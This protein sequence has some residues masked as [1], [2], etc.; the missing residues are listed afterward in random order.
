[1]RWTI[2]T[3]KQILSSVICGLSVV[4]WASSLSAQLP[5]IQLR[6][7]FP[8][9]ATQGSEIDLQITDG[10]ELDELSGLSFS[11]P[12]L[13][14]VNPPDPL[15]NPRTFRV[16]VSADVP[17]GYYA[18][19][20][21][22]R[23]GISNERL[24][25]VERLPVLIVQEGDWKQEKLFP[26]EP[27]HVIYSRCEGAGDVDRFGINLTAGTSY[28][29]TIDCLDIDSKMTPAISIF[30]PSGKRVEYARQVRQRD[31]R[32][33][34]FVPEETGTYQIEVA[35][36]LYQGSGVHSYRLA[37][38]TG[39]SPT[40]PTTSG[41][42]KDDRMLLP[43]NSAAAYEV[44][45]QGDLPQSPL[46]G[47]VNPRELLVPRD[48]VLLK[49]GPGPAALVSA[50]RSELPVQYEQEPNNET[51][52]TLPLDVDV[53]GT[54][55]LDDPH[56]RYQ[57]DVKQGE[58]VWIQVFSER[59]GFDTD[60]FLQLEH[61]SVDANGKEVVKAIP[62]PDDVGTNL[63][64]DVVETLTDDVDFQTTAPADGKFR[65]TVRQR[66]LPAGDGIAGGYR[67]RVT[68]G[69]PDFR[70]LV[71]TQPYIL[72]PVTADTPIGCVARQGGTAMLKLLIHRNQGFAEGIL[73][74][75][76]HAPPGVRIPPLFI[77]PGINQANVILYADK[78]A[79]VG[80]S[81]LALQARSY[82]AD[83]SQPAQES[84][85]QSLVP[86]TV[87]W[88][89]EN[90][91][92]AVSRQSHLLAMA[93]I[94]E[95]TPVTWQPENPPLIQHVSQTQVVWAPVNLTRR[96]GFVDPVALKVTG[97]DNNAKITVDAPAVEK[98]KTASNVRFQ[99]AADAKVGPHVG[100]LTTEATVQYVRNPE[101][102]A[103]RQT[104]SEQ[105]N[106]AVEAA[107]K[108]L[109]DAETKLKELDQKIAEATTKADQLKKQ[110]ETETAAVQ[111]LQQEKQKLETALAA[112]AEPDKEKLTA[113]LTAAQKKLEE[114]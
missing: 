103:R 13:E 47:F 75:A 86:V 18:V 106:A 66:S 72:G 62:V 21:Q 33:P 95:G 109:T 42:V 113:D 3:S 100:L 23:F 49:E 19:R 70:L 71:M 64:P 97:F 20:A 27:D 84:P 58:A 81:E 17:E 78:Q 104:E 35:D 102:L 69:K 38:M 25:R 68:H 76:P 22:G 60:P 40:L 41:I 65:I 110:V 98:E 56:D 111:T 43:Q 67:L 48:V 37:V 8:S 32:L 57:V 54:L 7:L 46:A 36:F 15:T 44:Q 87:A 9:G 101:L 112:A 28:R 59:D 11:H 1:M 5:V 52:Q 51:W 90:N 4:L 24:F 16:R 55:S 45:S 82:P 26:I 79:P 61:V 105:A 114:A 50:T 63:F 89:G 14:V 6:G 12:G 30:T 29:V 107:K 34:N 99:F 83:G 74:E 108:K 10:S 93:V 80:F 94:A 31:P 88:K 73:V 77:P 53:L 91:Q 96:E 2:R 92:P 85:L 39:Y